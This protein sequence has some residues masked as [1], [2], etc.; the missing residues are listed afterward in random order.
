MAIYHLNADVVK[1]SQG[2]CVTASAAY[3]AGEQLTDARL[4]KTFDYTRRSGVL[5]SEIMAPADAPEW[6]RNREQL[7]N[8][9]E[10]IEKRKDAQLARDVEISLPHELDRMQR[11][12][13]VRGFVAAEFVAKG[14]IADV[15]FHAPSRRGDSRNHHAHILL[16]MRDLLGDGFGNKARGWNE[17]EQLQHWRESWAEHVNRALEQAGVAA[18]VDHRSL[19]AQGIDREPTIH[20]GPAVA[21]LTAQGVVTDCAATAAVLANANA[22]RDQVKAELTELAQ[23][24]AALEKERADLVDGLAATG[25][26]RAD[27]ARSNDAMQDEK[28]APETEPRPA[29]LAEKGDA[30]LATAKPEAADPRGDPLTRYDRTAPENPAGIEPEAARQAQREA[31]LLALAAKQDHARS[32]FV[33]EQTAA[34]A[35]A[36]AEEG[37][38]RRETAERERNGDVTDAK[39]RYAQALADEYQVENPYGSLARAAMNEYGRFAKQQEELSREIAEAKNPEDRRALELRKEIE[40]CEYMVITSQRLATLSRVVS[41]DKDSD[42]ARRDGEWAKF[43]QERAT[44]LR[45]ERAEIGKTRTD[46]TDKEPPAA[47]KAKAAEAVK[48]PEAQPQGFLAAA[49]QRVAG[50]T[51]QM[52]GR[53]GLPPVGE[54]PKTVAQHQAINQTQAAAKPMQEQQAKTESQARAASPSADSAVPPRKESTLERAKRLASAARTTAREQG[55]APGR[56]GGGQGGGRGGG[57]SR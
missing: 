34:A 26:A 50:F 20:Q 3:R 51:Q 12:E 9:V 16:T 11:I 22:E 15:C 36:R 49:R 17:K 57:N 52:T 5:C 32:E 35:T 43:Y 33:K 48:A 25:Q 46:G 29:P 27:V 56:D 40:G 10:K 6:M 54:P 7:W 2:Q 8:A 45:T 24:I 31:A 55:S 21:E 47:A 42:Q 14:M 13:L 4:G 18:R 53:A 41:G 1:R 44:A 23:Q 37:T 30:A 19:A 28:T 39:G 38:R